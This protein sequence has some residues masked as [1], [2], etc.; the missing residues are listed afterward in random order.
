MTN[1]TGDTLKE[2]FYCTGT[3]EK[4]GAKMQHGIQCI[5]CGLQLSMTGTSARVEIEHV[6]NKI[7][8]A[9]SEKPTGDR[10]AALEVILEEAHSDRALVTG[11]YTY[12]CG[13]LDA[14]KS[15]KEKLAAFN[16]QE[17]K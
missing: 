13:F 1:N 4:Y 7:T 6:W 11:N 17:E 3:A 16:K 9:P 2:C 8:R 5:N 15:V 12:Q 10:M 14:L